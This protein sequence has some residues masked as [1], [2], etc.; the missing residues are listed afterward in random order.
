MFDYTVTLLYSVK[1]NLLF[2]SQAHAI[3]DLA[4]MSSLIVF[5]AMLRLGRV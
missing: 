2:K 1:K 4:K 5:T 3:N